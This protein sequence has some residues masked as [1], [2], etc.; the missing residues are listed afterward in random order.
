MKTKKP[1]EVQIQNLGYK[2]LLAYTRRKH[3]KALVALAVINILLLGLIAYTQH[4]FFFNAIVILDLV[5]AVFVYQK[6][7]KLFMEQFARNN[8][9]TYTDRGDLSTLNAPYLEFGHSRKMS[10]VVSG[11]YEKLPIRLFEYSTTI[12]HGKNKRVFNFSVFETTYKAKLKHI[13]LHRRKGILM[14]HRG[15][16]NFKKVGRPLKLE[17]NFNKYFTLY[18]PEDY[19]IEALQIFT[20]EIMV[21]LIDHAHKWNFEFNDNRL[22]IYADRV[23]TKRKDLYAMYNFTKTL[24]EKLAPRL[25]SFD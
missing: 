14:S 3:K 25:E 11:T 20:P 21:K 24:V 18:V 2:S 23:I 4:P 19:E 17:G 22:Y 1:T 12:G 16:I 5:A 9:Y 7:K 8:G 10:H 15:G 6:L 13:F